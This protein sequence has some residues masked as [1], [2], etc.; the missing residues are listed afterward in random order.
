MGDMNP[1]TMNKDALIKRMEEN[2]EGHRAIF[3]KAVDAYLKEAMEFFAEQ[4]DKLK[5]GKPFVTYFNETMPEDHTGD[6]DTVID[7]LKVAEETEIKLSEGD[8]RQYVR[9][10]WGWKRTSMSNKFYA[11]ATEGMS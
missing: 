2:R 6:Y 1:I 3:E 8:F 5:A 7:M 9:D 4:L 11:A 10:D